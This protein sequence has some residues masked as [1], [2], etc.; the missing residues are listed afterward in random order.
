M[1]E[2]GIG[3][4]W[5]KDEDSL[6]IQAVKVHGENDNWKTI[7]LYV[8]GRTNKACRKVCCVCRYYTPV[9]IRTSSAA[10]ASF[11][12][13]EYHQKALDGGGRSTSHRTLCQI[14]HE[15]VRHCQAH[16]R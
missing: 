4:P 5:T 3:K 14:S 9:K 6:L 11:L 2:R 12:V 8:P 10:V 7:A 16:P 1:K 15:V 13:S